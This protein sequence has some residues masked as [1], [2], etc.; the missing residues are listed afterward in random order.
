MLQATLGGVSRGVR[1]S[2]PSLESLTRR[3][4]QGPQEQ[5]LELQVWALGAKT[6]CQAKVCR[7]AR[8]YLSTA[9]L[10][11]LAFRAVQMSY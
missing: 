5:A 10:S 3:E 7:G 2:L 8:I 4:R 1:I 11:G 6:E 9:S